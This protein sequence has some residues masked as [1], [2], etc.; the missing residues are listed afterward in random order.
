M[1]KSKPESTL[2]ARTEEEC[3]AKRDATHESGSSAITKVINELKGVY[4]KSGVW[5]V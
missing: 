2:Y 5:K 1:K 4:V 3:Q